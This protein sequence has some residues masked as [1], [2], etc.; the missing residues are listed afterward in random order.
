MQRYK[1]Q[2]DIQEQWEY[3]KVDWITREEARNDE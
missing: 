3:Q 1:K 2:S